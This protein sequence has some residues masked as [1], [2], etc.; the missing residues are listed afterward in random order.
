LAR[1][2]RFL[3]WRRILAIRCSSAALAPLSLASILSSRIL[4]AKKRLSAWE[5]SC[6][7]LTRMPVGR[8]WSSTHVETLLTF[9]PPAPEDRT[10]CSSTSF[11]RTPR[12]CMRSSSF[13][14]FSGEIIKS[15]TVRSFDAN[16]FLFFF[17]PISLCTSLRS[18]QSTATIDLI[19]INSGCNPSF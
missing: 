7:H 13:F 3:F 14:S 17:I 12:A 4:R 16:C 18:E 5:R 2:E 19:L 15:A 10:N 9:W 8:W 6:W 1:F 11:S